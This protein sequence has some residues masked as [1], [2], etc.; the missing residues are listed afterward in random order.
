MKPKGIVVVGLLLLSILLWWLDNQQILPS[1]FLDR[2]DKVASVSLLVAAI[3]TMLVPSGS[4]NERKLDAHHIDL[5]ETG[6]S[7]YQEGKYN[8]VVNKADVV[9]I[10]DHAAPEPK[11]SSIPQRGDKP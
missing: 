5:R 7:I 4:S 6:A 9:N 2:W 1:A 3:V 8:A 10:G 11:S